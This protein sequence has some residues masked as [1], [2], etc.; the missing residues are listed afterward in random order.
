M[1]VSG[2]RIG[3]AHR[4]HLWHVTR[5]ANGAYRF[6]LKEKAHGSAAR[7]VFT[8][9]YNKDSQL[10]DL[11]PQIARNMRFCSC[12]RR[13]SSACLPIAANV[14]GMRDAGQHDADELRTLSLTSL[15]ADTYTRDLLHAYVQR[16]S[17]RVVYVC[18][19]RS[20]SLRGTEVLAPCVCTR[21]R[22]REVKSASVCDADSTVRRVGP[23]CFQYHVQILSD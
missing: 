15:S 19:F 16:H 2:T 17:L 6:A 18:S 23:G 12:T 20:H 4:A 13:A 7:I 3:A 22:S 21:V 11:H 10:H 1:T 9:Q 5:S 8:R 14:R